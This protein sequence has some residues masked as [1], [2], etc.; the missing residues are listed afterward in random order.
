[1]TS[2]KPIMPG[3][4]RACRRG[5][6]CPASRPTS[7]SRAPRRS[8][9]RRASTR[10]WRWRSSAGATPCCAA[11]T[12]PRSCSPTC[13][14]T[15]T[16]TRRSSRRCR[17]GDRD[18]A[19][20][21]RAAH[22]RALPRLRPVRDRDPGHAGPVDR[23]G[24]GRARM[25]RRGRAGA[26]HLLRR[27][28]HPS[29]RDRHARLRG[30]RRWLRRRLDARRR[31]PRRP[32]PDRHDAALAGAHLRRHG[33][34]GRGLRPAHAARTCRASSSSTRSAT[35]PRRR[36]ASPTRSAIGCTASASTRPPSAAA[37][38][39]S[40]S[41][42]CARGSTRQGFGHVK[43]IVSGGFDPERIRFFKEAGAPVDS[44]AVGSYIS[45]ARPI[46]FTGD[47]K[48]IDGEPI[49]K[50]G[51]IPGLTDSPRLEQVDLAAWRSQEP[52]RSASWRP[53]KRTRHRVA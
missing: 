5:T 34:R 16:R 42:R 12:R 19:Q 38:R 2:A 53:K 48:E 7:T 18:R 11:S 44:Y 37:S 4:R 15:R 22:S 3:I 21:S 1:M 49:A 27:A 14:A 10:S 13:C 36:C 32:C 31:A 26:G 39:P 28:P 52:S 8:S 6:S 43:I 41:A 45:G 50:R 23:L 35:R 29:G 47:L 20:G 17:D 51:R 33:P 24:N 9:P 40:S 30:D 25:R 46:D